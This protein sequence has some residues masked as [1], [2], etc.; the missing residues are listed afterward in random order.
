MS[1]VVGVDGGGSQTTAVVADLD[2]RLI[3]KGR[4]GGSNH[5]GPGIDEALR[6]VRRAVDA[7]LDA[8][9]V[10]AS[11]VEFVQYGLAGA[12]RPRDFEILR[13]ALATLPFAD[14][15][16]V[17]DA[18]QGLRAGTDDYIG[19]SLVCGSGTN[20]IGRNAQG[21]EVQVGGFGYVFGDFAGGHDVAVETF[22]AAVRS[23]QRREEATVLTERVAAYLGVPDMEAVYNKFLDEDLAVPLSLA[24]VVHQAADAGDAVSQRILG[25]MGFELGLAANAVLDHLHVGSQESLP[26]VLVGSVLQK[27]KSPFLLEALDDT[28]KIRYPQVFLSQLDVPP[29]FGSVLLALDR[30]G[31]EAAP[32]ARETFKGWEES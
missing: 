22:R 9:Q 15:D 28:V 11:A 32:S 29:V 21:R 18:W 24:L 19:V 8:A 13:P 7:A 2:G 27:G 14:W 26:V 1:Y 16:V 10:P 31:R 25:Q 3:A 17:S 6:Q 23:W 20:A 4:A 30:L 5:Q 12:D